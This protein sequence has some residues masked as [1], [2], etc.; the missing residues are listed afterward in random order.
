[1]TVLL[2]LPRELRDQ[3]YTY[4]CDAYLERCCQRGYSRRHERLPYEEGLL[5]ASKQ[6]R[7]ECGKV[8]LHIM[9]YRHQLIA[10]LNKRIAPAGDAL[11]NP[12]RATGRRRQGECRRED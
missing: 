10:R 2:D 9:L 12:R 4:Y 6:M 7:F 11:R 3:I 5:G 8:C 1:M